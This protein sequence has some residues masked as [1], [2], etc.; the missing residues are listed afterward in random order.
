MPHGKGVCECHSYLEGRTIN[1]KHGKGICKCPNHNMDER[2]ITRKKF[3]K[4]FGDGPFVCGEKLGGCG[5]SVMF[6][7]CCV[8]HVDGNWLNND[9]NNWQAM[10]K[11]CHDRKGAIYDRRD[12][13][14]VKGLSSQMLDPS[15]ARVSQ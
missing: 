3:H 10:H 11:P 13:I 2:T 15:A 5:Q 6:A 7:E 4:M 14:T 12:T 1:A 9:P 8:D